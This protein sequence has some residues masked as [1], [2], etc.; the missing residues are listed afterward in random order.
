MIMEVNDILQVLPI[1]ERKAVHLAIEKPEGESKKCYSCNEIKNNNEFHK[2]LSKK[3]GL[4][5][6]CKTCRKIEKHNSYLKNKEKILI[7][8]KKWA[9]ENKSSIR[10]HKS[11]YNKSVKGIMWK[12][13]NQERL[14]FLRKNWKENNPD[15]VKEY[16]K[17]DQINNK[18][19]IRKYYKEYKKRRYMNDGLFLL[20]ERIG[21]L[22]RNSTK[23]EYKKSKSVDILKIDMESFKMYLES[24]FQ[25]GMSWENYGEW[26]LDHK[27]PISLAK[28]E[29]EFY[30]LNH[31]LNFR[32]LWK[33]ENRS[34]GNILK[35]EFA[36][37]YE[38]LLIS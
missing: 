15:K 33:N 14:R 4:R 12:L 28:N 37:L 31:Y 3:D 9:G 35:P 25:E 30:K 29:H 32:P 6:N 34:K 26:E 22:I 24:L 2:D 23:N 17:R 5:P 20:R 11:K 19:R 10:R 1:E 18:V 13:E 27:V 7:A 21:C 16:K 36:S 8:N 38:V